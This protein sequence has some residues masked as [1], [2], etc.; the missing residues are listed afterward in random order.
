MRAMLRARP[1]AVMGLSLVL[2]ASPLGAIPAV[3]QTPVPGGTVTATPEP[4]PSSSGTSDLLVSLSGPSA[5]PTVGSAFVLTALVT[6][7]GPDAAADAH[8]SDYL[9]AS[10]TYLSATSSDA[11]DSCSFGQTSTTS[12]GGTEPPRGEPGTSTAPQ[13]DGGQLDCV[14][15]SLA[16]SES[17]TITISVRRESAQEIWNSASV[18]SSAH[19][20]N[21]NDNYDEIRIGP[22]T[23]NPAD[24]TVAMTAPRRPLAGE[25]FEYRIEVRNAGPSPASNAVAFA[26][27]PEGVDLRSVASSDAGD[28][29]SPAGG[30]SPEPAGAFVSREIRCELGTMISGETTTITVAVTRTRSYELYNS[31]WTEASNYDPNTENNYAEAI[32][33]ADDSNPADMAL[34]MSA[35]RRVAMGEQFEY[36][37]RVTNEGPSR[38]RGVT[39]VDQLPGGVDYVSS[40]V[41]SGSGTCTLYESPGAGPE[42]PVDESGKEYRF[43]EL[44]C[45]LGGLGAGESASITLR[46]VRTDGWEIWNYAWVAISNFDPNPNNDYDESM[47]AADP[48][49]TSD[50]QVTT[51]APAGTPLVGDSFSY[52]VEVAN[53]GP[54]AAE[55]SAVTVSL[56]EGV[57][58]ERAASSPAGAQ[59]TYNDYSDGTVVVDDAPPP[60]SEGGGSTGSGG[61]SGGDPSTGD[62]R[63]YPE[64][65]NKV[66]DCSLGTLGS[67][68]RVTITIDVTRTNARELW[69]TASAYSS[70]Y[71]PDY[72]NNYDEVRIGPDTSNPSDLAISM[73]A[74][75]RPANGERFTYR[76][77]VQNLGPSRADSVTVSDFLPGE[78]EFENATWSDPSDECVVMQYGYAEPQDGSGSGTAPESDGTYY[79]GELMCRL[80]SMASGEEATIDI[81]VIRRSEY[82]I[83]NS[84]G[85]TSVNYDP[86]GDND[87]ASVLV[88]GKP[89]PSQCP[90]TTEPDGQ[91]DSGS[92]CDADS[93]CGTKESDV[94]VVDDCAVAAGGGSDSVEV[95]AGS[96]SGDMRIAAGP[97]ADTIT[98]NLTAAGAGRPRI[99]IHG[100]R[101]A[102]VIRINVA[103]GAG[104]RTVV[105]FGE[106]G[107]DRVDVD[108]SA[109]TTGLRIVGRGGPGTDAFRSYST[110]GTRD[111]IILG[112]TFYGGDGADVIIGGRGADRFHGE[113]DRD[114]IDGGAGNDRIDGGRGRDVCR[115]G[116]G[117]DAL[118]SC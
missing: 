113:A 116:P 48:S 41:S 7:A 97:G 57:R 25:D 43:R 22:D 103:P 15:G 30:S 18:Y 94:I 53:A 65:S 95:A 60:L 101:G 62:V 5:T 47:V 83:W 61:S 64:Y 1:V 106:R 3:A 31:A 27:F 17:A 23:S 49:V 105:I 77:R 54:A 86:V 107:N 76:L 20:P 44:R 12:G 8:L 14:L 82:E 9:P 68:Q 118:V 71:D 84:A 80:G 100:G 67:G 104:D 6:N 45:D 78:V 74:P 50:L 110:Q 19:E 85:V 72:E 16:R 109:G 32:V 11:S 81:A 63:S 90:R 98:V 66:L 26:Y 39:V 79:G 115:G 91:A 10:L 114:L 37:L 51:R 108:M 93:A 75:T 102:D 112:T 21:F 89:Y 33:A 34:T 73:S 59:C 42:A 87:Y 55:Q 111:A 117:T 36:V 35:P 58:Y 99:E 70:N 2:L 56:P 29:C 40:S 4:D 13:S 38:G 69:N 52:V 24:L 92:G 28:T 88:E 46:V 96:R